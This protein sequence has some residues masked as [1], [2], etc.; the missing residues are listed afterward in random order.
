MKKH[1]IKILILSFLGLSIIGGCDKF[2]DVESGTPEQIVL[3]ATLFYKE[4]NPDKFVLLL[5]DS[6]IKKMDR[7]L[8]ALRQQFK[9]L[10]VQYR[11]DLAEK[12]SMN[13]DS[14]VNLKMTDY[15]K[16][17][18]NLNSFGMGSDNVLFPANHI[19]EPE[20]IGVETSDA[21]SVVKYKETSIYLVKEKNLWK[22]DTFELPQDKMKAREETA[23]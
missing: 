23:E 15:I 20:Y 2:K 8:Q 17:N 22:I 6:A 3:K 1:V 21:K 7:S 13:P 16:F 14:L 5:S 9:T 10:D 11:K 18:M 12:M 19:S 4:K